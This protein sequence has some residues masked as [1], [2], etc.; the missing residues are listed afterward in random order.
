MGINLD[1]VVDDKNVT[2]FICSVCEEL[3]EDAILLKTC[4]HLFCHACIIAWM[5]SRQKTGDEITCPD[6]R[7]I[8]SKS[9]MTKV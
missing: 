4:D 9:D 5:A 3:L 1:L 2:H 8:F 7:K 6:C